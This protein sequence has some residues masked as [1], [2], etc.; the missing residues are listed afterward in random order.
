M[1][2]LTPEHLG[3]RRLSTSF[4]Q[5]FRQQSE[6]S[7]IPF[8]VYSAPTQR[9]E[10]V[11]LGQLNPEIYRAEV[12]DARRAEGQPADGRLYVSLSYDAPGEKLIVHVIH[13]EGLPAKDFSGTSDPYVKVY[14]LPDR[15]NKVQTY[16]DALH[17][18]WQFSLI[19]IISHLI[20]QTRPP[21]DTGAS[22]QRDVRVHEHPVG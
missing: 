2:T 6:P 4:P 21:E 7:L 1:S 9:T 22:V 8:T 10:A 15:R 16:A 19:L 12:E 17:L 18:T 11:G 3:K 5:L 14:V 13:A 20:E